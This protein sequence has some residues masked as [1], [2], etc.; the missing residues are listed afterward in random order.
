MSGWFNIDPNK[1]KQLA[2]TTLINAQ[3]QIGLKQ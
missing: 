2:T 1:L 3:K